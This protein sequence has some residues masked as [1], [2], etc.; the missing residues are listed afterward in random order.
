MVTR[1]VISVTIMHTREAF[2]CIPVTIRRTRMNKR[3][4]SGQ[5]GLITNLGDIV[6]IIRSETKE[7]SDHLNQRSTARLFAISTSWWFAYTNMM[8]QRHKW[9]DE[10]ISQRSSYFV[11]ITPRVVKEST[12]NRFSG[13]LYCSDKSYC[14]V[15]VIR[16]IASSH[17]HDS[18]AN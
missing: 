13:A 15:A 1:I 16:G 11:S 17:W 7:S 3:S 10:T 2:S 9:E 14:H 4:K 12:R 18:P 5:H 6:A 8:A